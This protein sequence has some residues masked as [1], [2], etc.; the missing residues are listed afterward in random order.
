MQSYNCT[1]VHDPPPPPHTHTHTHDTYV[2]MLTYVYTFIYTNIT[3]IHAHNYT[4]NYTS[5]YIQRID[6]RHTNQN[7]V[8]YTQIYHAIKYFTN[9]KACIS[10]KIDNNS[11]CPQT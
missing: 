9:T 3:H 7:N 4:P 10:T 2:H 5:V 11:I 8:Y 6:T 1:Y